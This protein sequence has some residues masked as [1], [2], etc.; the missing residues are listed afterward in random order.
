MTFF[1]H[2]PRAALP[3]VLSFFALSLHPFSAKPKSPPKREVVRDALSLEQKEEINIALQRQNPKDPYYFERFLQGLEQ[4]NDMRLWLTTP[5]L[6]AKLQINP[7][8]ARPFDQ[9]TKKYTYKKMFVQF[10]DPEELKNGK[11]IPRSDEIEAL[12]TLLT[13]PQKYDKSRLAFADFINA[14]AKDKVIEQVILSGKTPQARLAQIFAFRTFIKELM[15]DNIFFMK[16]S[17]KDGED[18][19]TAMK[20]FSVFKI[21]ADFC[22]ANKINPRILSHC[23][24]PFN[25]EAVV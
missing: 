20:N 25:M 1:N 11:Y 2:L 24:Y 12:T 22:I 8:F 16:T 7:D 10:L 17:V 21:M 14:C 4:G 13:N 5:S 15:N 23:G 9:K 18:F 19:R 3:V 6:F